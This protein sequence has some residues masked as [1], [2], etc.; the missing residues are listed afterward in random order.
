MGVRRAGHKA[1]QVHGRQVVDVVTAVGNLLFGIAVLGKK[2][3]Q[4]G[5]FFAHVLVNIGD[6][7][8]GSAAAD[9]FAF[10]SGAD[11]HPDAGSVGNQ[12]P[13]A[14]LGGKL[15]H[16]VAGGIIVDAAVGQRAVHIQ[17]QNSNHT[18]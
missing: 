4:E 5:G 13:G 9:R 18:F 17:N 16:L 11:H 7:Q 10:P 12:K 6:F 1:A 8:V 14:V 15:F 3:L 2:A